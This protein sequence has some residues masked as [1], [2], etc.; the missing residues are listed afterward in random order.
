[1][2]K[3]DLV[4]TNLFDAKVRRRFT[5]RF[6]EQPHL[7]N[8]VPDRLGGIVPHTHIFDHALSKWGHREV[9]LGVKQT[10][11]HCQSMDHKPVERKSE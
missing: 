5:K 11:N 9:L 7:R 6:S 4:R 8:V 2:D 10:S 1:M 3:V